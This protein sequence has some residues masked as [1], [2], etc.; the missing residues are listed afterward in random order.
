[1]AIH[2]SANGS[3]SA[4][5]CHEARASRNDR[6]KGH[7]QKESFIISGGAIYCVRYLSSCVDV[8]ERSHFIQ[9]RETSRET[10]FR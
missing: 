7:R 2:P 9:F 1:M 6:G 4:M 10:F 5:D 8:S 3:V